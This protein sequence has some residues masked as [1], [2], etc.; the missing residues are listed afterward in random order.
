MLP[1]EKRVL[2]L[3]AELSTCPLQAPVPSPPPTTTS[4]TSQ[5]TLPPALT[6]VYRL[7]LDVEDQSLGPSCVL[8][9]KPKHLNRSWQ[10][11]LINVGGGRAFVAVN[12][13]ES[14]WLEMGDF[15]EEICG[16]DRS[17]PQ[18]NRNGCGEFKWQLQCW[19]LFQSKQWKGEGLFQSVKD[20]ASIVA[21]LKKLKKLKKLVK[22]R[23]A[24]E[25]LGKTGDWLIRRKIN[26]NVGPCETWPSKQLL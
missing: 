12:K 21:A 17:A 3:P 23:P 11:D 15:F 19:C 25:W 1:G 7:F 26:T 14:V 9:A 10:A 22:H 13:T 4:S 8:K 2:P 16:D 24:S 5:P 18:R 6:I 20:R